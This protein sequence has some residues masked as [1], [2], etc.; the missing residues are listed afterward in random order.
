MKRALSLT[1]AIIMALSMVGCGEKETKKVE[2]DSHFGYK[3]EYVK[4]NFK[5]LGFEIFAEDDEHIAYK[6]S[7]GN[8][9]SFDVYNNDEQYINRITI[10]AKRKSA[11]SGYLKEINGIMHLYSDEDGEQINSMF[12]IDVTVKGINLNG[13]HY[14]FSAPEDGLDAYCLEIIRDGEKH[15]ETEVLK[16]DSSSS[17]PIL[18][19]I[20]AAVAEAQKVIDNSNAPEIVKHILEIMVSGI[21]GEPKLTVVAED[22][23][24][25]DGNFYYSYDLYACLFTTRTM[26]IGQP[27]FL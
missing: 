24:G 23:K 21:T 6:N 11:A 22:I 25:S 8:I 17:S 15:E 4:A 12:G 27:A 16:E 9:I 7:D 1:L 14:G 3:L 20:D 5:S 10:T 19:D 26:L 13:T 2:S 18:S